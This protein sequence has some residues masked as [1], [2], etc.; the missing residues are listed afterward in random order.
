VTLRVVAQEV[1][2]GGKG[3]VTYPSLNVGPGE[4]FQV[5]I[6]MQLVRPSQV[7]GAPLVQVDLDGVLFQD[8]SFFGPDR[9]NSRRTMTA[10]EMEAQRDRQY[11]KRI[12]AQGDSSG[13]QRLQS[14]MLESLARQSEISQLAVSVKR[15]GRAV[16][17]A[18]T[19]SDHDAEFAFLKF[20]DS[21]VE[22]LKGSARISGNEARTPRIEVRNRSNR[23][24]KYVEM[25]WIVSDPSGKQY[26]AGSLPSADSDVTLPPGHSARLLQETTL[27]FSAKGQPVNVRNMV[28]F[29]SQVEFADGKIWVP[30][31]QDNALLRNVLPP[32]AEEQRLTDIYRKRGIDALAA[33]LGKF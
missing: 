30:N 2:L 6:D 19:G 22:P 33:E 5:R 9:L 29:V 10:C 15:S 8:L 11:F 21:P 16:T 4:T 26:M 31:R 12:L 32:S 25:G 23:P 14:A 24:V 27:N 13:L 20:P 3:S 7:T 18:A 1:T 28:G 17:S